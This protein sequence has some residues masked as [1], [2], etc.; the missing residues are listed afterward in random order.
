MRVSLTQR[1]KAREL[2]ILAVTVWKRYARMMSTVLFS[3]Q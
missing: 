3:D 2:P 1:A